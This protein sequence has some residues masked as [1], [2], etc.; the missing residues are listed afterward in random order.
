VYDR[1]DELHRDFLKIGRNRLQD[2]AQ[3]LLDT[4]RVQQCAA[5]GS[6]VVQWLDLPDGPFAL[7]KGEF[8]A[9]ALKGKR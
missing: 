6:R 1:R 3:A 8:A 2:M 5:K 4:G 9:G 7:G